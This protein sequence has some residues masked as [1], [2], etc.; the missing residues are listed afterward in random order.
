MARLGSGSRAALLGALAVAGASCKTGG[1]PEALALLEVTVAP[2]VSAVAAL[3]FEVADRETPPRELMGDPRPAHLSFGYYLPGVTGTVR[4]LG[5]ALDSSRCVLG[6]GSAEVTMKAGQ[7]SSVVT[8]TIERFADS[9]CQP[10]QD[11]GEGT[12]DAGP[13]AASDPSDGELGPEVPAATDAPVV[14]DAQELPDLGTPDSGCGAGARRCGAACIPSTGCCGI[15][16]CP[17]RASATASCDARAHACAYQC[18]AGYHGCGDTCVPS[19]VVATCG[20]RCVPCDA[21]TGGSVTCNGTAC[22]PA[23]PAGKKL[24]AGACIDENVPCNGT[25]PTGNP[26]LSGRPLSRQ[27]HQRLRRFVRP[28][29]CSHA[30]SLHL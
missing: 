13:D 1:G 27:R 11:A 9:T 24:C 12:P 5:K 8:L 30:R 19:G 2:D 7:V 21:P 26:R 3:R 28:V 16:D 10:G 22:V 23:C 20:D 4:V 15:A 6:Q 18:V 29:H 25:C 17:A 14:R